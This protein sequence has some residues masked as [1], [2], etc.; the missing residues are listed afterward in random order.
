MSLANISI[1]AVMS[2]PVQLQE[3]SNGGWYSSRPDA[4]YGGVE[5]R[6]EVPS[7]PNSRNVAVDD[8]E[9][10]TDE[11]FK[12]TWA[13]NRNATTTGDHD[14]G[15]EQIVAQIDDERQQDVTTS[16][17]SI[18]EQLA[19][20]AVA[21]AQLDDGHVLDNQHVGSSKSKTRSK[22]PSEEERRL[23]QQLGFPVEKEWR[24]MSDAIDEFEGLALE[25]DSDDKIYHCKK[26][27]EVG[28]Y[29]A[30]LVPRY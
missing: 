20:G 29:L 3:L 26:C 25:S 28:P 5:D 19:P 30:V 24:R 23:R 18:H 7:S 16:I 27:G 12:T 14:T 10:D 6:T 21:E 17:E 9:Y 13:S 22:E 1:I 4:V 8:E 2:L 11:D 15:K